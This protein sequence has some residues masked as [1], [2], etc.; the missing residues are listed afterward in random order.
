MRRGGSEG[1]PWET[2]WQKNKYFLKNILNNK[3]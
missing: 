3:K 2:K 1:P